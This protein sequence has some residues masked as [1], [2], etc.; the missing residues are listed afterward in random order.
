MVFRPQPVVSAEWLRNLEADLK[1][2]TER[3]G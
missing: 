3:A 2:S 1:R